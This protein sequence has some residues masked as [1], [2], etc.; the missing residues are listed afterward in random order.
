MKNI[1]AIILAIGLVITILTGID[2]VTTEKV[3]DLGKV[4]IT[5]NKKH[6][7]DWSPI[8][9]VAVMAVGAGIF[10]FGKKTN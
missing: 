4:E 3:L 8:I 2:F 9:G 6:R 1:G 7:L 5:H 10:L